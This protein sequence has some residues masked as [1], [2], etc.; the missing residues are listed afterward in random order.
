MDPRRFDSLVRALH[1]APT[2]REAV[3]ALL[4]G[5][6]APLLPDAAVGKRGRGKRNG[7]G[8]G[9]GNRN[10]KGK[11]RHGGKHKGRH[12]GKDRRKAKAKAKS[13]QREQSASPAQEAPASS[14]AACFGGSPCSPAAGANLAK[15][16]FGGSSALRNANLQR[17]NLDSANLRGADASGAVLF[18]ANMAKTCLVDA[19]LR[20]AQANGTTN[21]LGAVYCRTTMPNGTTNNSGCNQG[22]NCCP[23]CDAAHPCPASQVCCNGRCRAGD[24]CTNAQCPDPAKPVCV[25]NRCA[26]CTT[27]QQC[28][29]GKVCCG[30]RC[31]SGNCCGDGDCANRPDRPCQTKRCDPTT[32][33]CGYMPLADGTACD[34]GDAC[35]LG[36][37]CRGGACVPGS[38]KDC[39]AQSDAC[40]DGVCRPDGSCGKQPKTNG[41]AC[42]ADNNS[43]TAG[44]SCQNG[45]CTPGA[46]I[47]C[48]TLTDQCNTGVCGSGGSC[49]REPKPNDTLCVAGSNLC[50]QTGACRNGSC[51]AG[52]AVVCEPADACHVAGTC[53]PA[54]GRCSTPNAPNG[55]RCG[56]NGQCQNGRCVEPCLPTNAVCNPAT[57]TC[58]NIEGDACAENAN[59][60]EAGEPGRCCRSEGAFCTTQCDCCDGI[61]ADG[62]CCIPGKQ[63]LDRSECCEGEDCVDEICTRICGTNNALC[64][65][66]P[67]EACCDGFK[68]VNGECWPETCQAPTQG[69]SS[70]GQCCPDGPITCTGG[71]C[72]YSFGAT[73]DFDGEC[74]GLLRCGA[75][76]RCCASPFGDPDGGG[77]AGCIGREHVCCPGTVCNPRNANCCVPEGQPVP[78]YPFGDLDC[79]HFTARDGVC[80]CHRDGETCSAPGGNPFLSTCCDGLICVDNQCQPP[81]APWTTGGGCSAQFPCCRGKRCENFVC[82]S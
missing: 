66:R 40:N 19:N 75:Q 72:C 68:C 38:A 64:S 4:A 27:S 7:N 58:C 55:T 51:A 53:D 25:N 74:C 48:T 33:T 26:P 62:V 69:C 81:C 70:V 76:S 20:G 23:T 41:T 24:C 21:W 12:D 13:K 8:N 39:S 65:A 43:C 37:T 36:D 14:E 15:C 18:S 6:V 54:T 32:S 80:I 46:G 59:C 9:N 49:V 29:A 34:D 82:V 30:G 3:V 61:C 1:R 79:C 56:S 44:D 77:P 60:V 45:V 28:G 10:D 57:D 22:T 67:G 73:C 63:C 47:D 17:S 2:R 11:G 16:D 52:P 35:T 50:I 78:N 71:D 5:L 31:R 42:N